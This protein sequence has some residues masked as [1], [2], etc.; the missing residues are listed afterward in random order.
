MGT[1]GGVCWLVLFLWSMFA[2][3]GPD[4]GRPAFAVIEKAA[5]FVGF[6]TENGRRVG[7]VKVGSFP[8]EAVLSPDGRL[9]YVTDNGVLW[10][11]DQGDGG[12]TVSVV[13]VREMKK[14]GVIDLG[15]FRRPHGI[16]LDAISGRLLVTT[17]KPPGLLLID[18]AARKVLRDYDVKGK[19]PHMVTLGPGGQ[20]AFVSNTDS[21]AVAGVHLRSGQVKLIRTGARPQGGVLAPGADRLYVVNSGL[22]RI[23][24]IDPRSQAA[25]GTIPTGKGPGRIA[26]TP[27]GRTLVYNLQRDQ[28]VGF[29]D[30]ASGKQVATIALGGRPLSLTMTRDGERAFASVQDQDRIFVVSVSGRKILRVIETPK[31]AGPDPVVPLRDQ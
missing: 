13:D 27:D 2:G 9:L 5:G 22:D 24:I 30:V 3:V 14:V 8:H 1:Q 10:M 11:T 23:T 12:N 15:C 19:S 20:W 25:V 31:G 16:A 7:G 21:D 29:A 18:A 6:Y 28:G 26:I 4:D 17:E